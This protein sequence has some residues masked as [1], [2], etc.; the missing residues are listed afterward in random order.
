MQ[1]RQL[2]TILWPLVD[3]LPDNQGQVLRQRFQEGKTLKATGNSLGLTMEQVRQ[4]EAKAMRSLRCSRK[5]KLLEPF[6]E[7]AA[8]YSMG[9]T[10]TGVKS[11]E[12]TWTS[13]TERAVFH[14]IE[15]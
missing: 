15:K 14:M 9:L 1:Q 2:K 3:S 12:R 13:S 10:G 8:V 11:F 4:M 7:D 6:L 5:R